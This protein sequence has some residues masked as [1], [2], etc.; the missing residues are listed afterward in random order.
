M[1]INTLLNLKVPRIMLVRPTTDILGRKLFQNLEA[2]FMQFKKCS[3]ELALLF[4]RCIGRCEHIAHPPC[5]FN[6]WSLGLALMKQLKISF[7]KLSVNFM[8]N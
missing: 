7:T 6:V 3:M 2:S 1:G 5:W 8:M 4:R